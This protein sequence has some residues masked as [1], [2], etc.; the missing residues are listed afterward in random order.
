V[1]KPPGTRTPLPAKVPD[2]LAQRGILAAHLSNVA[3][4]KLFQWDDELLI[5][6]REIL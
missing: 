3:A 1:A 6:H 2:H 5:V 4:A